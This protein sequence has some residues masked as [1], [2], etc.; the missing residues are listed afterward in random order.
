MNLKN[1]LKLEQEK[2]HNNKKAKER[3]PFYVKDDTAEK[4]QREALQLQ[5]EINQDKEE[6]KSLLEAAVKEASESGF[7]F[8]PSFV[9]L[10]ESQN[11]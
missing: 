8:P 9:K 7:P 6:K 11:C 10:M 4:Q 3:A 5:R 1:T 2:T